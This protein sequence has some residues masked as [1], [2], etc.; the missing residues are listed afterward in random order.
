MISVAFE[1]KATVKNEES[2]VGAEV[3]VEQESEG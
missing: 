2:E 1:M 3:K